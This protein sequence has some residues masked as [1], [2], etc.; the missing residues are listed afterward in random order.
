MAAGALLAAPLSATGCSDTPTARTATVSAGDMP[1]G[2]D[3]NGVYFSEL[4]GNLHLVQDGNTIIGKWQRPQKDRWGEV[5]GTA[6]GDLIRFA[7]T[8]HTVGAVGPNSARHGK[9]YLKYRRPAGE[10]VVDEVVGEIG[11]GDDEVGEPWDAKK[12]TNIKADLG[13]IGGTGAG[14]IG[15]G[16]WDGDNKEKG[17]P[18]APKSPPAP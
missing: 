1:Q 5:K 13:S 17:A 9:G 11:R 8:E 12:Q 16:D 2:A 18:E 7:W 10:H 6:T 14:D 3:W 15:G 4:Y